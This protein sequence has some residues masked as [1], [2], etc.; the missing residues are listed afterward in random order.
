M[1]MRDIEKILNENMDALRRFGVK[2]IGVFGSASRDEISEESDIDFVVEFSESRGGMKDFIGLID[3]LEG[4]F[5]RKADVL[6]PDGIE[7]RI[8]SVKDRIK[9]EFRYVQK[10]R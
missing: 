5:D 1:K 6:T 9:K 8:K 7:I 3:F 2:R 4:L 10:R